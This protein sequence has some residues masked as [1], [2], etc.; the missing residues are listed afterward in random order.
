MN[1]EKSVNMFV[2]NFYDK[3]SNSGVCGNSFFES[4]D[5]TKNQ[6]KDLVINN[7]DIE[8]N[9]IIKLIRRFNTN[10]SLLNQLYKTMNNVDKI[11]E[12]DTWLGEKFS[13]RVHSVQMR[14]CEQLLPS[15]YGP[16]G[17]MK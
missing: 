14:I 13:E 16:L 9:E 4:Y 7:S 5:I 10:E 8:K 2:D 17:V 6:F 15:S 11:F 1:I 12:T 3:P